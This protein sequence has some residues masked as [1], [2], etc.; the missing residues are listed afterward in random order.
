MKTN[1]TNSLKGKHLLVLVSGSIAAVKTPLLVSS[2]IKTG[3][4]VRCVITP[5][6]S[7]LVSAV[8]LA[9]LSRNRCYQEDDQWSSSEPRPL[10]I[11][12]SEWADLV[13]IAPLSA[14]TLG[15]WSQGLAQ[16]LV[17]SILLA[18]EKPTIAAI[19]MNTGMFSNPAIQR[20]WLTIK[21]YPNL[22]GL[23]P[24]N[25]LLACNRE[26]EG[27]MASGELIE[28]A[29]ESAFWQLTDE[30]SIKKDWQGL[31]LLA[32]AGPTSEDIDLARVLTNRSSG[33]MGILLAQAAKLRG[34]YVDLV[35]GRLEVSNHLLEGLNTFPIKNANEMREKILELQP[36]A[37]AVS[38][39]A[40]V[41]DFRL[42]R[43]KDTGKLRKEELLQSLCT[44]LE[45]VP[46]LL[47]ELATKRSPNQL[48]L[49]FTAL[50]G[51]DSYIKEVGKRKQV[52]KGC[53]LIMANPIDRPG[54]GFEENNNGGWLIS[55]N[56]EIR[57]IPTMEKFRLA[58]LLLDF[59]IEIR[60]KSHGT[61]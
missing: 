26:G 28:L 59:L 41:S 4:E 16:G 11:A 36:H 38:M 19:A 18:N 42:Q 22:I 46:D 43:K 25:G 54:Q 12:L 30:G 53:D 55:K 15:R 52:Q 47:A 49:G 20:N 3:A 45:I 31:R 51:E 32:T 9:S 27:R 58:H 7:R 56:G 2:L 1:E 8:S 14:S 24:T 39:A 50:S 40:A 13:V 61:R 21:S 37:D 57:T 10:H 17:A 23:E 33:K 34:A 29:I 44:N 48:L 35:H 6:A 5:S 60:L